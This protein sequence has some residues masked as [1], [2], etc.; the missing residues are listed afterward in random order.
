MYFLRIIYFIILS[1][2]CPFSYSKENSENKKY[3]FVS[4]NSPPYS[5][6][7][8][9]KTPKG[10]FVDVIKSACKKLN[11][12]CT[13]E[14]IP[15]RRVINYAK[16]GKIDGAFPLT[17]TK[18]RQEIFTFS[19]PLA[20][21]K[22]G[23]FVRKED[24]LVVSETNYNKVLNNYIISSFG[25]SITFS[26]LENIAKNTPNLELFMDVKIE[27]SFLK[28]NLNHLET[29]SKDKKSGIFIDRKIGENIIKSNDL[30]N[31]RYSGD[32]SN[33]NYHIAFYKNKRDLNF[34]N[35]FIKAINEMKKNGELK[36][37]ISNYE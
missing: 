9:T 13:I 6:L 2:L 37:I 18:E 22:L 8:N 5:F 17:L 14:I 16:N 24:P 21:C 30:K 12:E 34:P 28:L 7:S 35:N 19:E 29:N 15:Y 25:P 23:I 10:L 32:L 4:W 1:L 26:K 36:K 31:L 33:F 3:N 11:V 27:T 20:N